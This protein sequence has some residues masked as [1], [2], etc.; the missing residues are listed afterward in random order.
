MYIMTTLAHPKVIKDAL[1]QTRLLFP[2]PY[3]QTNLSARIHAMI[4]IKIWKQP[5]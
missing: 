3:P 2:P 1:Q 5:P 4:N